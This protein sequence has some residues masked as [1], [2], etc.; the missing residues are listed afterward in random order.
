MT[1]SFFAGQP[2]LDWYVFTWFEVKVNLSKSELVPVGEVNNLEMFIDILG[3]QQSFLP[4]KYLGLPLRAGFKEKSIYIG[5][6]GKA[7]CGLEV[8]LFI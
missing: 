4:M 2:I 3:C 1:P 5:K 8:A 6:N 7:A